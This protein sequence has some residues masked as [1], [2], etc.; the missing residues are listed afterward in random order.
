MPFD[1]LVYVSKKAAS[2]PTDLGRAYNLNTISVAKLISRSKLPE[3]RHVERLPQHIEGPCDSLQFESRFESGNLAFA[4][5]VSPGEY[6][7]LMSSDVNSRGHTQWFFYR[8]CRTV[9]GQTVKFNLLNFEKPNSLY[10]EGMK[11]LYYSTKNY[12]ISGAGWRRGGCDISYYKNGIPRHVTR[13][14]YYTMTFT[15]TFDFSEDTV[16]FAYCFPYTYSE[17]QNYLNTLEAQHDTYNFITRKMLCRTI[18]GNKCDYLT[19]TNPGEIEEIEMRKG[20]V[21]SARV[22]PGETVGSWMMQGILEFLVSNTPEADLLRNLYVFK[23]VPMLNPDGVIKGNHRCSLAGN[24]LNRN[25]KRPRELSHPTISSFKRLI[26]L[27]A[28]KFRIDMICDLHGH[29]RK[30]NIFMYGCNI[31]ADPSACKLFPYIVSKVSSVFNFEG[32]RF[33]MQKDKESTLRITLFKELRLPMVFT[34]EASFCGATTGKYAGYHFTT[35][36]LKQMG[37][38]LCISLLV[39]THQ[40]PKLP[41]D[42]QLFP[43]KQTHEASEGPCTLLSLAHLSP[44]LAAI[45]SEDIAGEFAASPNLLHFGEDIG[46]SDDSD[47]DPSEDDLPIEELIALMPKSEMKHEIKQYKAIEKALDLRKEVKVRKVLKK[48]STIAPTIS[49]QNLPSVTK[50]ER[51]REPKVSRESS[52][53]PVMK[54]LQ[55]SA[56]ISTRRMTKTGLI[57]YTSKAGKKVMDQACQTPPQFYQKGESKRSTERVIASPGRDGLYNYEDL[58]ANPT[59]TTKSSSNFTKTETIMTKTTSNFFLDQPRAIDRN[60]APQQVLIEKPLRSIGELMKYSSEKR[61]P[62]SIRPIRTKVIPKR[63]DSRFNDDMFHTMAI[64]SLTL[65]NSQ[66]T[67]HV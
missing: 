10:N 34:C 47:S 21:L 2:K 35:D 61:L 57:Y 5:Q 63:P 24:D 23:I 59:N 15:F 48:S 14:S 37:K 13:K 39:Y 58:R 3:T 8:V 43:V 40:K 31:P 65:K 27:F 29:S 52:P 9:A 49:M 67:S 62:K 22:H 20:I 32:C 54:K 7:L 45:S 46:S 17:L 19:I 18:A 41:L 53:S 60:Y 4:S 16:Y 36:I 50:S 51:E 11:V 12:E 1:K 55:K 26:K 30:P 6:N 33:G 42:Q 44:E 56:S 66:R 28:S 38:D 25:W 64:S